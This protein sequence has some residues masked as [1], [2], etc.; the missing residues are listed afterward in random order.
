MFFLKI[1]QVSKS[2]EGKCRKAKGSEKLLKRLVAP[3]NLSRREVL[4]RAEGSAGSSQLQLLVTL[5]VPLLAGEGR[6]D[7]TTKHRN[8]ED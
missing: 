7:P 8:E 3:F 5:S 2:F 1:F 4:R 6:T